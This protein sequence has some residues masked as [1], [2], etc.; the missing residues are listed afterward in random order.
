MIELIKQLITP[1]YLGFQTVVLTY[2]L[3]HLLM[4][5]KVKRE[6][7]KEIKDLKKLVNNTK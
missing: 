7:L 5:Y 2:I 6:E 3:Y 4:I 1:V